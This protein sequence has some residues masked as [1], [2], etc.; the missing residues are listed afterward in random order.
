M[1]MLLPHTSNSVLENM[2]KS[3]LY[4]FGAPAWLGRPQMKMMLPLL[5]RIM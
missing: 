4:M 5:R 2:I 1:K 3:H